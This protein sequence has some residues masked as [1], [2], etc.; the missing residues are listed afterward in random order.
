[1]A[2]ILDSEAS[3]A[4]DLAKRCVAPGAELDGVTLLDALAHATSLQDRLPTG[5]FEFLPAPRPVH[6]RPPEKVAVAKSLQPLLNALADLS[7]EVSAQA[8]FLALLGDTTVRAALVARGLSEAA[9]GELVR[10]VQGPAAAGETPTAA[11]P[12]WRDN[13]ERRQAADA[14]AS[15]GR[16]LTMSEPPHR[17]TYGMDST[18]RELVTTLSKMGNR[19]AI[20]TGA[21]GVGKSAVIYELARRIYRGDRSIPERLRDHDIFELSPA[22]LRS[23]A[24]MVGQYEERIKSLMQVLNKY[25]KIVLF[26]DEI[27][28]FLKSAMHA[29]DPFTQANE[30]LKGAIAKGDIVCLGCTTTAEY[31]HYIKPDPAWESRF[32]EIRLEPPDADATVKILQ[33]RRPRLEAH[34]APLKVPDAMLRRTVELTDQYL[35]A[36]AQPRKSIQLV[37]EACAVSVTADPPLA[38]V[39]EDA[40]WTALETRI[41]RGLVRR[42]PLREETVLAQLR[43]RITGQDACLKQIARSFVAGMGDWFGGTRPRGVWFFCGPTGVGKTEASLVLAGILGGGREALVRI[44]CNALQGSGFDSGPAINTLLGAPP[45]YVGYVRG[46]GGL[47]S[48]VRERPE[49]IV[50]FDEIEKADPGVS[51]LL[52]QIMDTGRTDDN[53]GNL[54][55]FRRAFLIFTSNAGCSYGEA[56][57]PMGFPVA[58]ATNDDPLPVAVDDV[59]AALR[60]I[61]YGEEFMGRVEHWFV[62]EAMQ[63]ETVGRIVA[64][65]LEKLRAAA[66]ERGYTLEWDTTLVETL[67]A[68]WRP[69]FGARH[70]LAIVRNRIVGQLAVAQAGQELDGVKRIV[71][72]SRAT[73]ALAGDDGASGHAGRWRKGDMLV[74]EVS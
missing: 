43:E 1:M 21:A 17:D 30:S 10:A 46:Q 70:L 31:Q 58:P 61:G 39:G 72:R 15:F 67:L 28:S 33:A 2:L 65:E 50:L 63:R 9:I 51:K 38:E 60:A 54:L 42:G 52:L 22:F 4:R 36:M 25:P 19:S 47:L 59:R 26:V 16:M 57:A 69:R 29:P 7:A 23:G 44:N 73:L 5:S 74:I 55:D 8:L 62:F 56:R 71:L 45:G 37:D 53:E 41:G 64:Q 27:H 34:F 68:G 18:V 40:L 48:K 66:A 35:P 11:Q 3:R 6:E 49:S 24:S 13:P 32:R 14:L 12:S 20:I